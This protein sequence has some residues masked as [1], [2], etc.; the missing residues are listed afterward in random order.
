M[1]MH[2]VPFYILLHSL[3]KIQKMG[4]VWGGYGP[5]SIYPSNQKENK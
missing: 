1:A 2:T 4:T 3:H 5:Q